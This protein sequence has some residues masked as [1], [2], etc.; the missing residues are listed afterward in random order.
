MNRR[1][2]APKAEYL[3]FLRPYG[4]E[5]TTLALAVREFVMS[6]ARGAVELIYDAYNAVATGYS[7]TGR[8]SDGC[9]HIAVYAKWVNLG[10]QRGSQLPDPERRLQGS[11]NWVRHV[12]IRCADDLRDPAIHTL[13][14]AAIE[15][16]A[17]PDP[18]SAPKPES[19]V[20]AIYPRKRRPL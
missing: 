16:A 1:V 18:K 20:R 12:R 8:P 11:G 7:F 15:R 5:I 10:F 4:P 13:V 17:Y 6:E 2:P 14:K 19:V 3:E 9:I